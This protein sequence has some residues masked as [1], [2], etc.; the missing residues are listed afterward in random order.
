[1]TLSSILLAI[2]SGLILGW[3]ITKNKG[4]DFSKLHIIGTDD[5]LKNMR[6]GQ[7]V[8]I[9]K[10]ELFEDS[11]IKGARN[12]TKKQITSKYSKLRKDLPV[13]L[14]CQNGKKSKKL[15]KEMIQKGYSSVYV[16]D[17]GFQN[18]DL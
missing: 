3:L 13:Y 10:K 7:L 4:I 1:M 14:Y 18:Y 17:G 5:F 2:I 16:L 8:D 11:K 9:R 15:A 6:K 12:F